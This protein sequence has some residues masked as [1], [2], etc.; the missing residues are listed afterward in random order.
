MSNFGIFY[1]VRS[2]NMAKSRDPGSK[3][4]KIF[5][6]PNSAF[7]I[8]NSYKISSRNALYFRSYQPKTSWGARKHPLP[9][10]L[11]GLTR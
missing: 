5:I 10:V 11:L 8:R 3:F 4:R 7:N 2:L 9:P 1:N 6:F